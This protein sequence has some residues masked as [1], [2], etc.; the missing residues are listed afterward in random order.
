[1][2]HAWDSIRQKPTTITTSFLK[3]SGLESLGHGIHESLLRSY[4]VLDRVKVMLDRGDSAETVR[5]FI[6]WAEDRHDD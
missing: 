6:A 1:L 4:H 3:Q 2:R 5:E